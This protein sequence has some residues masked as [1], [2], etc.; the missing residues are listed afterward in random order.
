MGAPR[1]L[2][3][4]DSGPDDNTVLT[5]QLRQIFLGAYTLNA[6]EHPQISG[7]FMLLASRLASMTEAEQI[8]TF[9]RDSVNDGALAAQNTAAISQITDLWQQ[10]YQP[11]PDQR[12]TVDTSS[13]EAASVLRNRYS[14]SLQ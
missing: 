2:S 6:M 10:H 12:S 13:A 5:E 4:L 3:Y 14:Q 7:A 1:R 9:M 11:Q 8:R